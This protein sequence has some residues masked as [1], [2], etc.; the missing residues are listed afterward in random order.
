MLEIG[1]DVTKESKANVATVYRE[2]QA[3]KP[4]EQE[5]ITYMLLS[6]Q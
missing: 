2:E 5:T 1:D 6:Q 4:G 3:R